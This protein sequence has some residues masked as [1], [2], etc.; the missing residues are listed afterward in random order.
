VLTPSSQ[1][2]KECWSATAYSQFTIYFSSPCTEIENRL[3][4]W[5]AELLSARLTSLSK[6]FESGF[7]WDLQKCI[8]PIWRSATLLGQHIRNG[9]ICK[10]YCGS[11]DITVNAHLCSNL[12][13]STLPSFS[14]SSTPVNPPHVD[15]RI[16]ATHH[17]S[18]KES[19]FCSY[20][21]GNISRE[22]TS[23]EIRWLAW[24]WR[25]WAEAD[26]RNN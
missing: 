3:S 12:R 1:L 8:S 24:Q 4:R 16:K 18:S 14:K 22:H 20:F 15:W 11:A 17:R 26:L 23:V 7:A 19:R 6:R 5:Q 13:V 10:Q 21:W 2:F 9:S 25:G